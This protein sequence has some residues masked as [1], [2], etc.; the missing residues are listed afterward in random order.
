VTSYRDEVVH[1]KRWQNET[2]MLGFHAMI[3]LVFV[4]SYLYIHLFLLFLKYRNKKKPYETKC[5]DSIRLASF[6]TYTSD[7]CSYECLSNKT[8][9]ACKCRAIGDTGKANNYNTC[10]RVI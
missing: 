8:F 9:A 7:G 3:S 5:D 10:Q 4:I 2:N 6:E 1:P